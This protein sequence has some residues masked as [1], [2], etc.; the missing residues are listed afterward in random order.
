M[1]LIHYSSTWYRVNTQE[2][3]AE[4]MDGGTEMEDRLT[5]LSHILKW[6]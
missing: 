5:A 4:W 6:R 1:F 2:I 3:Y